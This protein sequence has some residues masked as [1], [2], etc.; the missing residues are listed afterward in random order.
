M[1]ARLI[2]E[3]LWGKHRFH[4]PPTERSRPSAYYRIDVGRSCT[5]K[6]LSEALPTYLGE[7]AL[8]LA[9]AV[10]RRTW[11][12][13]LID[14]HCHMLPGIDDGAADLAVSLE[15]ARIAV[16]DGISTVVCTPHILPTVYDN[17]GP[18]IRAAVSRLQAALM[19]AE[20]P[21]RV[22]PG[23]DVHI[24]PDLVDGLRSG[25]VLCVADSRYLL[26]EPPHHV[27]PPRLQDCVFG[28]M[29][30][31]YLPIL[32]HPERLTWIDQH[33]DVIQQLARAGMLMQITGGSLTGRF[34]KRVR[35]WSQRM[36]D[37]GLVDI[38]ATDAHDTQA[39]PP[40]LSEA[41]E[42]VVERCGDEEA[43]KMVL[44]RPQAILDNL[45]PSDLLPRAHRGERPA[46]RQG[47]WRWTRDLMRN[48]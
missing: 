21:L 4:H 20:I 9:A 22:L 24:A 31:G 33:Y 26:L 43:R 14:L 45:D 10:G 25:R 39:R 11:G 44:A 2:L 42:V 35:H 13:L 18:A 30:A 15:M 3:L 6:A 46:S 12:G 41:R 8:L 27:L 17:S 40:R 1:V 37:D 48:R 34:G 19:Q 7:W 47:L 28:L 5:L 16:A 32:T 23:A 29:T 38:L 36:L